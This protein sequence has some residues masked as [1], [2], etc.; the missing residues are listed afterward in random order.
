MHKGN[1]GFAYLGTL[2][3]IVNGRGPILVQDNAIHDTELALARCDDHQ[4]PILQTGDE[5]TH[6]Y[7]YTLNH[8]FSFG[9][10]FFYHYQPLPSDPSPPDPADP[11]S[12]RSV[13]V[14]RNTVQ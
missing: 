14:A 13:I 12:G 5:I 4:D 8:V 9:F 1:P 11:E 10:S 6:V 3:H 2:T 7:N